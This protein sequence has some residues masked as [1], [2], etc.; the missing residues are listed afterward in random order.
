M[1]INWLLL[2]GH[3]S[4]KREVIADQDSHENE[5]VTECYCSNGHSILADTLA[6]L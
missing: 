2:G 1:S 3:Q 6:L 5:V 4:Q